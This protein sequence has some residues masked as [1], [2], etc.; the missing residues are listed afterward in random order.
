M[1]R[2]FKAA[3]LVA[4][5]LPG[6]AAAAEL[7]PAVGLTFTDVT[8]DPASGTASGKAGWQA[9]GT[10]V[11]GDRLYFEAGAFYAQKGTDVTSTAPSEPWEIKGISGVRIPASL[12]LR[13]LG[14][15]R[16]S[17]G[18]RAFGGGSAFIV[19]SVD[20]KGLS[21]S[22]FES[23]TYGAFLGGGVDFLMLFADLQ[24]EWGLTNV[25]KHGTIDVG[26]SRSIFLNVG[27]RL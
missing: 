20:A 23:P 17:L 27:L 22:D 9:G 26:S 16:D 25:G 6:L 12:G 8:K 13:F 15:E 19:T 10:L 1:N 24:Y 2:L 11:F 18:L 5:L 14:H 21:K 3:L 4:L 7:K